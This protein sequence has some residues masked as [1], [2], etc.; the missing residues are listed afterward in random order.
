VRITERKKVHVPWLELGRAPSN[1]LDVETI[2]EG[3]KVLDP[4]KLAKSMISRLWSHW[5]TRAKAKLPILIFIKAREQDMGLYAGL[6]KPLVDKKRK[7]YMDVDSDNQGCNDELDVGKGKDRAEEGG[8]EASSR[9]PSSKRTRLSEQTIVPEEE[10]PAANSGNRTEF[11]YSLSSDS[12]YKLLVD[13][14]LALPVSVSSVSFFI[15]M[16]LLTN[17]YV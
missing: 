1:Y 15:Y 11:L 3:F 12:S 17:S 10:S 9:Q 14:V 6:E 4:S 13:I 16:E 8:S 5:S 2:P 7:A